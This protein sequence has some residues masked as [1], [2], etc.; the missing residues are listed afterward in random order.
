[1][2][3]KPLRLLDRVRQAIR[4]RHYSPRTEEAYVS[5]I[6]R[7]I[8]FHGLR[9]PAELGPAEVEAFLSHLAVKDRVAA[10]T[11]NQA[12]AALLFLYGQVLD[13]PLGT[14]VNAVRA[15]RPARLPVVL[16]REEAMAVIN[17]LSGATR[18]MA[19]LLYGS[20]LRGL[21]CVTLRIKDVDLQRREII[22]RAGKG[23]K[24]R[25]TVLPASVTQPLREHLAARHQQYRRDLAIGGGYSPLPDA[26]E[27]KLP[28]ASREWPWQSVF[29]SAVLRRDARNGHLVRYH[30]SPATLQ[31]AVRAA[32]LAA[33]LGKRITCHALRHSFATQLLESGYDIRTVQELLGHKDVSTTMIYTHVLGRGALAVVSPLDRC[34]H[35]SR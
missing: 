10:A 29:A 33:G 20:G 31:R 15:R 17:H 28:A 23:R 8:A 12:L 24:D 26:L 6:R 11:Q 5:W 32:G 22:V 19:M 2:E 14:S 34:T 3:G 7:Y 16:T 25:V 21:E 13:Q 4:T 27:R 30:A 35:L 1:M 18:L 9:H